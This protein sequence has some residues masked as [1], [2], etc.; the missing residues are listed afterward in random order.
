M[1][2]MPI[3]ITVISAFVLWWGWKHGGIDGVPFGRSGALVTAIALAFLFSQY[4][5]ILTEG[6]RLIG[7]EIKSQLDAMHLR[8][9]RSQ[10]AEQEIQ[11]HVHADTKR[12][13]RNITYWQGAILG[14]GT[15]V[16]G[17]GDL[18]YVN[19]KPPWFQLF[20]KLVYLG[21]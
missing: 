13:E 20:W 19:S 15:L 9:E 4:G 1:Y 8:A 17:F 16:W 12:I 10:Q 7:Q 3:S 5:R 11:N 18:V 21:G 2:K 14:I 6:E